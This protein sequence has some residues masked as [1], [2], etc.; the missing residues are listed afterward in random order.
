MIKQIV[1]SNKWFAKKRG[2]SKCIKMIKWQA[3]GWLTKQERQ[4]SNGMKN[5]G[6]SHHI[7]KLNEFWGKQIEETWRLND[8][9]L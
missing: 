8:D 6:I 9:L 1:V 3:V 7:V 4:Q 5:I 2:A